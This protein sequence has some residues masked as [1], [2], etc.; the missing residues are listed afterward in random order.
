MKSRLKN[1]QQQARVAVAAYPMAF[2]LPKF[3]LSAKRHWLGF[4]LCG[5]IFAAA[6]LYIASVNAMLLGGEAIR[7]ESGVLKE[8]K[9]EQALLNDSAIRRESPAWLE[10]ESRKGGMVDVGALRY[11]GSGASVAFSR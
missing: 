11:V 10:D 3:A 5:I 6:V 7:K 8:L 4:F 1:I 9:R 2:P